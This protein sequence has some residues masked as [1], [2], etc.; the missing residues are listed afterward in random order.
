M[1]ASSVDNGT[2]SADGLD[3]AWAD[4]LEH[5][6]RNEADLAFRRRVPMVVRYLDPCPGDRILDCGCGMG[7]TLRALSRLCDCTLV[8][9]DRN[10]A[11]LARAALEL[12]GQARLAR[13]DALRLPFASSSFDKVL[14]TEVL[15]HLPDDV[16]ALREVRRVLRVGGRY[17]ISV[18]N[19]KYPFWWDPV[20]KL[21]EGWLGRHVPSHIWWAAGIWADHMRLYSPASLRQV[22][23][24]NGFQVEELRP[25]THYCLPFHHFLVYGLGKNLLQRGLLPESIARAADRFRGSE[26]AGSLLNPMNLAHGLLRWVDRR[27]EG[28]AD[29]ALS[30]VG[31]VALARKA[32]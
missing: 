4:A 31:I 6:L 20:N 28:L 8:G 21:L 13:A 30:Y 7:F 23:E 17:V 15:E 2:W 9:V 18:P 27:N 14:M 22:L 25:H 32:D 19:Q 1:N 16:A 3:P 24:G 10:P 5:L 11:A 26:N 29:P 12:G